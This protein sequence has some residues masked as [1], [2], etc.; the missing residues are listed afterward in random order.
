MDYYLPDE[1]GI[2]IYLLSQY[3]KTYPYFCRSGNKK[4]GR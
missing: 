4:V 3:G 2:G 1:K